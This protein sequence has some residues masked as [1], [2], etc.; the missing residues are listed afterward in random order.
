VITSRQITTQI[1]E[2]RVT[3]AAISSDGKRLVYA[4]VDGIFLRVIATGETQPL[5][6]PADFLVDRLSWFSDGVQLA[7]GGFFTNTHRHL[8]EL[9]S[10]LR[11]DYDKLRDDIAVYTE[12]DKLSQK[13]DGEEAEIGVRIPKNWNQPWQ[14][15]LYL[16]F[17]DESRRSPG[18]QSG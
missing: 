5:R 6:A 9:A 1:P 11:L 17:G 10:A 3:A 18:L 14:L 13:Y 8:K 7:A 16:Y 12:P 2:N 15:C 4:T